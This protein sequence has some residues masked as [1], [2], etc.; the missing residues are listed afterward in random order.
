MMLL[1]SFLLT[2]PVLS[3]KIGLNR[4]SMK[5][6]NDFAVKSTS[7]IYRD[8]L[9]TSIRDISIGVAVVSSSFLTVGKSNAYDELVKVF[10]FS[11]K[12]CLSYY[13]YLW[14]FNKGA[15]T[16]STPRS[17]ICSCCCQW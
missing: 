10:L 11:F 7:S 3:Y 1:F 5:Q 12:Q 13:Y 17:I 14:P 15:S 16:R 2:V 4:V 8:K 9:S 6:D